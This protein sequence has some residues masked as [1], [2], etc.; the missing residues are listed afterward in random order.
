MKYTIG[1]FIKKFEDIPD[2]MWSV[3]GNVDRYGRKD[4]FGHCGTNPRVI[5]PE[6][7][8]I[9]EILSEKE[10]N[11]FK[12]VF[13]CAMIND[14]EGFAASLGKTPKERVLNR[15]KELRDKYGES[16]DFRDRAAG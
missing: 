9:M 14:G 8:A 16:E 6:G 7:D 11:P 3:N 10:P 4:V 5:T 2:D 13:I 1:Y 12:S 15:L